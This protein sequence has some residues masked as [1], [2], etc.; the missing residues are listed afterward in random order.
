MSE[1]GFDT[2][3]DRRLDDVG[4]VPPAATAAKMKSMKPM[5]SVRTVR[6]QQEAVNALGFMPKLDV[7]GEWGPK[8]QAV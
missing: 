7:D 1:E 2:R 5:T 3:G 4:S 8:T 6:Q